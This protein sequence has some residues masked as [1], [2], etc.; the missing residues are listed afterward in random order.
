MLKQNYGLKIYRVRRVLEAGI[1]SMEDS[2]LF[3]IKIGA[4]ILTFY[5]TAFLKDETPIEYIH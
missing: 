4:P 2:K 5:N 1:A 3:K